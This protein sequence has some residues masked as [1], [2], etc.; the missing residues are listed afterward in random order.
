[1][2]TIARSSITGRFV[3]W[4][5]AKLNPDTTQVETAPKFTKVEL[6]Y[7]RNMLGAFEG[8]TRNAKLRDGLIAKIDR[9]V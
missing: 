1:M 6:T 8:S 7:I 3:Q 9:M 5:Y 4:A 2:T